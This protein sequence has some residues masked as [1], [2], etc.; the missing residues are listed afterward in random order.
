[1]FEK[2]F[3]CNWTEEV[4]TIGCVKAT[5]PLTYTIKDMLGE[6][7]HFITINLTITPMNGKYCQKVLPIY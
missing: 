1:M 4:F 5:K 7:I 2:G 6:P 3:T